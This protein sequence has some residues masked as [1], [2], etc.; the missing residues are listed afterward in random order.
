MNPPKSGNRMV[1]PLL[2]GWGILLSNDCTTEGKVGH[3]QDE[4]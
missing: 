1:G 3:K 2:S 4:R